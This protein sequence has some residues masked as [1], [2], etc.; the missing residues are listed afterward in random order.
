MAMNAAIKA[1]FGKLVDIM[2][3]LRHQPQTPEELPVSHFTKRKNDLIDFPY[4]NS[5][6]QCFICKRYENSKGE[7]GPWGPMVN[8]FIP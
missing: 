7:K 5:G 4:D 8:S 2:R 1:S 3:D 6:K